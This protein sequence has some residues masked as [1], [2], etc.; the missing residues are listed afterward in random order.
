MNIDGTLDSFL[1][2][3]HRP[4]IESVNLQRSIFGTCVYEEMKAGNVDEVQRLT[5]AMINYRKQSGYIQPEHVPIF[6]VSDPDYT[7]D[8]TK[9]TLTRIH[10]FDNMDMLQFFPGATVINVYSPPE[11]R[12][13]FKYLFMYKKHQDNR[14]N[15][16][17]RF[18]SGVDEYWNYI[19]N[20]NQSFNP[21]YTN[22]NAYEY[23]LGNFGD[24]LDS[25][26]VDIFR[27]NYDNNISFLEENGLDHTRDNVSSDELLPII[28]N[29]Y[30]S[31]A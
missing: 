31:Y 27:N 30:S 5:H 29:M 15:Q 28:R 6:D 22:V 14:V 1:Y 13:I 21:K 10:N 23:L 12:W 8:G 20:V 24:L 19:W 16:L 3:Y 7:Y 17:Q 4:N 2:D 18:S 25:S 9:K 26:F 11:K